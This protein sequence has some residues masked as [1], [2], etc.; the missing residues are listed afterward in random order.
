MK[1]HAKLLDKFHSNRNSPCCPTHRN[2]KIKFHDQHAD[3]PD[4]VIKQGHVIMIASVS[5]VES[6]V[7]NLWKRGKSN[8]RREFPNFGQH[9]TINYFKCLW[10]EHLIYFV[11]RSA[12]ALTRETYRGTSFIPC[13]NNYN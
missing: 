13:T 6:G 2:D 7:A 10:Q 12:G 8:G 3:D 4:W 5:E 11:K 1:G 9:V